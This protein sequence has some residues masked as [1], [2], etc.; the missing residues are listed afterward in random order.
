MRSKAGRRRSMRRAMLALLVLVVLGPGVFWIVTMP[1]RVSADALQAYMPDL[2]NGKTMFHA[3]G[4]NSCHAIPDEEDRTKLGGGMEL[5]SAYGS[6]YA[7]NISPHP[8]D[9]IGAW[10][11]ADFVSAMWKGTSPNGRHYFP[12]FPYTSYR[13]M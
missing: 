2:A 11:E 9:G 6:F 10:S 3:G 13:H 1:S 8:R 5:K 12:A 4:C 7:P